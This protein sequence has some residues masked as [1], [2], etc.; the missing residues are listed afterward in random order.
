MAL[1]SHWTGSDFSSA[2]DIATLGTLSPDRR[3]L[4]HDNVTLTD[5]WSQIKHPVHGVEFQNHRHRLRTYTNCL[6]GSELIDW[7]I[8]QRKSSSRAQA[9]LIG[10]ALIDMKILECV[11]SQDQIFIDGYSL[12]KPTEVSNLIN[13]CYKISRNYIYWIFRV[14]R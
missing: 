3:K 12:Y 8:A 13:I 2:A 9:V 7:L 1:F 4:S 5:L 10:Q 14:K 11:T 6:V